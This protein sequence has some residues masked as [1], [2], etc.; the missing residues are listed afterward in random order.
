MTYDREDRVRQSNSLD[1]IKHFNT[2]V[3]DKTSHF[4][5]RIKLNVQSGF[6]DIESILN[7][8]KAST[9]MFQ[10]TFVKIKLL[11]CAK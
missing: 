3:K 8:N 7:A 6:I 5:V 11:K 4:D 1:G 9:L 2:W 10:I